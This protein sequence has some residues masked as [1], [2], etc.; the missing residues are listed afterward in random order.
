MESGKATGT[1]RKRDERW[2]PNNIF[3][4]YVLKD[5]HFTNCSETDWKEVKQICEH[6]KQIFLLSSLLHKIKHTQHLIFS[7]YKWKDNRNYQLHNLNSDQIHTSVL[8]F[9]HFYFFQRNY[10]TVVI[11]FILQTSTINNTI[12]TWREHVHL[13]ELDSPKSLDNFLVSLVPS[14][15]T[16]SFMYF[17]IEDVWARCKKC[18]HRRRF[19]Y[20]SSLRFPPIDVTLINSIQ[21]LLGTR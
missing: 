2:Y 16:N 5:L 12:G 3:V 18:T 8:P 19:G 13:C 21:F 14:P 20:F 9:S 17:S 7:V 10:L 1:E 4:M 15:T 11:V 6:N